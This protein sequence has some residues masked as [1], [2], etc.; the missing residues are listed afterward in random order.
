MLSDFLFQ[1]L[2]PLGA[3][4]VGRDSSGAFSFGLSPAGSYFVGAAA[5]FDLTD[6]QPGKI[7]VQPNFDVVFLAPSPGAEMEIWPRS[8]RRGRGVGCLLKVTKASIQAAAAAGFTPERVLATLQEHCT[9]A[10]PANVETEITAW[11]RQYRQ[12]SFRETTLIHCPD[13]ETASRILAVAG[14]KAVKLNDTILE[15]TEGKVPASLVKKLR[16][17]GIFSGL[18]RESR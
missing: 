17:M 6:E 3:V 2:I 10:L 1:R 12:I 15:W 14:R 9:T 8:E 4:K 16:E 5:D 11:F 7:L 13:A 18:A